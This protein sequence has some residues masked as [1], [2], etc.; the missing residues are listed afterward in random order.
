MRRGVVSKSPQAQLDILDAALF[1][2]EG[3]PL[4]SDRFVDALTTTFDRLATFPLIGRARPELAPGLRSFPHRTYVIFY[5]P[6][7]RGVH[8]VRVLHGARDLP[9]LLEDL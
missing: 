3:D 9:P 1:I 5:R 7:P 6:T 4:A 8:I 2:A